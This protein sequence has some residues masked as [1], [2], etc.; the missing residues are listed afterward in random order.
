MANEASGRGGQGAGDRIDKVRDQAGGMNHLQNR[1]EKQQKRKE[2]EKGVVGK[3]SRE[4]Q[5]CVVTGVLPGLQNSLDDAAAISS[6]SAETLRGSDQ[7]D[8]WRSF[9]IQRSP[10]FS[11]CS[12]SAS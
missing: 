4:G 5:Q 11:Y 8:F 1:D 10:F 12:F 9:L 6:R 2:R 3:I 7:E